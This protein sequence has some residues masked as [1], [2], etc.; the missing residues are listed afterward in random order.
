MSLAARG[1]QAFDGSDKYYKRLTLYDFDACN[2][3][4]RP[5]DGYYSLEKQDA[6]KPSLCGCCLSSKCVVIESVRLYE[7]IIG[8]PGAI[9]DCFN[10][11]GWPTH[12]THP[13]DS[14]TW[15]SYG[16]STRCGNPDGEL[17]YLELTEELT[18]PNPL[19]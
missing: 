10:P 8:P 17:I 1:F 14:A 18:D 15:W 7:R 13:K 6:D 12:G 5:D 19:P 16:I 9:V 2:F 4:Y 11:A 3:G